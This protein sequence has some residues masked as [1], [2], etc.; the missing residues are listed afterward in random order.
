MSGTRNVLEMESDG[1]GSMGRVHGCYV[2]AERVR[3]ERSWYQE[4]QT[5]GNEPSSPQLTSA[6]TNLIRSTTDFS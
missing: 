2:W 5:S 3:A 6:G 1:R 4:S